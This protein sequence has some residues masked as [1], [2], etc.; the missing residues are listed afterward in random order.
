MDVITAVKHGRM[1]PVQY[2]AVFVCLICNMLDGFDLFVMGFALPHLPVGFATGAEKGWLVSV[3]LIGMAVGAMF[4]APVADRVGRRLIV[5][6]G[7]AIGVLS[8]AASALST[9]YTALLVCRFF[10]GLGVGM[11]STLVVVLALEYSSAARRNLCI[12]LVT[13]GF[14]AGSLLG[15]AIGLFFLEA[16]GGGWQVLFVGG[17]V[18]NAAGLV[19]AVALLPESLSF[20]VTRQTP[21]AQARIRRI[22]ERMRLAG[23]DP[24]ATPPAEAASP[25]QT[26]GSSSLLS[27]RL[28]SRTLLL[29]LG[30][31]AVTAA[32]YFVSTWTPQL[33]TLTTGDT[34]T[35]TLVGTLVSVGG[36]FG[37][38]VFSII[39]LKVLA[40]RFAWM[41]LIVAAVAQ[42]IFALVLDSEAALIVAVILGGGTFA[43]VSAYTASA[44][45][46]YPV[47][48][49]ARALGTFYG[50]S[51]ISSIVAPL[52]AGYAL[53]LVSPVTMY[54]LASVILLVG[55]VAA[56]MLW[57]STR[58]HFHAEAKAPIAA[59]PGVPADSGS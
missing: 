10:T 56:F 19:L 41:T 54:A 5:L 8:M 17:A 1:S 12:G 38:V 30:Y 32:F 3:G 40:T 18:L 29:W 44:P 42:L 9:S 6:A 57:F 50:I 52:A 46:L 31:S 16:L 4:L 51:R 23:V 33:I 27:P 48:L 20:L 43:A 13:I 36:L 14:P 2:L 49:R 53:S 7:L 34:E 28:R 26:L 11:V 45:P 59:A 15:G 39:G 37:A 58:T 25:G 21:A 24:Q 47:L 22:A 35:G 55:A